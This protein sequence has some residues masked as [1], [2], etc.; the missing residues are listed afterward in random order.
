VDKYCINQSDDVDK[1]TQ[2]AQ[3]D[4]I[5]ANAEV[6]IVAAAGD[7]PHYGLPGVA[8]TLRKI[9]PALRIGQYPLASTLPYPREL[10][11]KSKW[12]TRGW[13]FQEGILSKRRLIFTDRQVCWECNN[14][15]CAE[16]V[17]VRPP[18]NDTP[19]SSSLRQHV[20]RNKVPGRRLEEFMSFVSE[21]RGR[22][23]TYASYSL[24]ALSGI[25]RAF[26]KGDYP[27]HQLMGIPMFYTAGIS[28]L[29]STQSVNKGFASGL[30]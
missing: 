13:T 11:G 15:Q 1:A 14:M 26:E 16:A 2:I 20:L 23:L 5:Y 12:A 10:V 17:R 3:M 27:I 8:G 30:T 4:L 9:Q 21:F 19:F 28:G 25:F 22:Y 7:G 24:R 6:T 18:D 29:T